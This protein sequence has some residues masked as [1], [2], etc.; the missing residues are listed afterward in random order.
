[1]TEKQKKITIPWVSSYKRE[2]WRT[3]LERD[4]EK[5]R[6]RFRLK[7]EPKWNKMKRDLTN[8][9]NYTNKVR[10]AVFHKD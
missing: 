6:F 10:K 8:L 7:H 2:S 5:R 3:T 1:M 9:K 4:A